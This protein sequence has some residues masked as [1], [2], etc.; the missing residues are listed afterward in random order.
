ML[1]GPAFWACDGSPRGG[2]LQR[3]GGGVRYKLMPPSP[4]VLCDGG[5][6]PRTTLHETNPNTTHCLVWCYRHMSG[7]KNAAH[8]KVD[9]AHTRWEW[10]GIAC[11]W[12]GATRR[13]KCQQGN[14]DVYNDLHDCFHLRA[15]STLFGSAGTGRP[16]SDSAAL[17]IQSEDLSE[18]LH[19][20]Q[21]LTSGSKPPTGK[22]PENCRTNLPIQQHAICSIVHESVPSLSGLYPPHFCISCAKVPN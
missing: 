4:P 6:N 18:D 20:S 11:V 16:T 12:R 9:R 1:F 2:R 10:G 19:C 15:I 17:K 7:Q 22:H 21:T 8:T 13:P 14:T 3:G 5:Q